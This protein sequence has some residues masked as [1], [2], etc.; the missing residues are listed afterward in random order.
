MASQGYPMHRAWCGDFAAAVVRSVGGTPPKD[1]QVAS[2]WRNWGEAVDVPQPG[3]IAVRRGA[4]T[5]NIGSHVTIV[6]GYDA[7]S[8]TFRGI[9]G[10]QGRWESTF[11]ASRYE[12]RRAPAGGRVGAASYGEVAPGRIGAAATAPV[13]NN[14]TRSTNIGAVNVTTPAGDPHGVAT[15]VWDALMDTSDVA[16]STTGLD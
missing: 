8:G 16:Q 3:D 6:Q 12:F 15:G 5:G 9:G 14:S 10:N 2:N 7:K 11:P 13:S 1:A 4:R